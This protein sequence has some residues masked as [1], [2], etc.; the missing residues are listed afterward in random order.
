MQ[1]QFRKYCSVSKLTAAGASFRFSTMCGSLRS[2]CSSAKSTLTAAQEVE[3]VK[4][5]ERGDEEAMQRRN[6]VDAPRRLDREHY[7][8]R[9]RF[10]ELIPQGRFGLV[11]AAAEKFDY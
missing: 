9:L 4:C 2:G 1:G 5:F 3:L 7:R 6:P 11:R 8:N 10:L